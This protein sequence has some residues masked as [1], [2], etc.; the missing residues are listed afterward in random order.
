MTKQKERILRVL[1]NIEAHTH[2]LHGHRSHIEL[3]LF[4]RK[5]LLLGRL[6][7]EK[8]ALNLFT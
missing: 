1:V 8:S 7:L 2:T 3:L 6:S 4:N 5:R